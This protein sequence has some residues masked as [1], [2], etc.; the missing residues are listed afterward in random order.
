MGTSHPLTRRQILTGGLMSGVVGGGGLLGLSG[1]RG[2]ADVSQGGD[3]PKGSGAAPGVL[4]VG[5]ARNVIVL[6]SDGAS[7]GTLTLADQCHR[8]HHGTPTWW[9]RIWGE[10]GARRAAMETSAADSLVT[11]SA[12]AAS[13]WGIGRKVRNTSVNVCPDGKSP[14]PLLVVANG[15]GWRTGLVTTTRLTDATPAGFVANVPKRSME[16]AVGVQLLERR[17]DLLLGG[18][19]RH[20]KSV[21]LD[22]AGATLLRTAAELAAAPSDLPSKGPLV[23]LFAEGS[24][25]YELDR[26]DLQPSLAEMARAAI[27]RL[28][29]ATEGRERGFLLQIEGG[30][31]DHAAHA[32]DAAALISD[33][34]AFDEALGVALEFARQRGGSAGDTLIIVTTDHGNANPGLTIY[35]EAGEAGLRR[36]LKSRRSF[37]WILKRLEGLG[38]PAELADDL[39]QVVREASG[40]ELLPEEVAWVR[41]RLAGRQPVN[42]FIEADTT[43]SAL[44]AV[45]ANHFGVAFVSVNHTADLVDCVAWGPG[46]ERLEPMIA[47]TALHALICDAAGLP[48]G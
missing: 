41:R 1:A 6:V 4:G 42:G 31:V 46:A 34:L 3:A 24:M 25:A 7:M 14:A 32:N 27:T 19:A 21:E 15:A 29:K 9:T 22:R 13:A 40:V 35:G 12:A 30:R 20:F 5:R 43:E 8:M 17:V 23:G 36:L 28:A 37:E 11:D 44:G 39:P 2:E 33:Q 18:G 45:L 10:P 38:D 48:G 16:D 26:D 47:N